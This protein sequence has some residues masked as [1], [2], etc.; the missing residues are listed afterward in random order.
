MSDAL[1]QEFP[2]IFVG[3]TTRRYGLSGADQLPHVEACSAP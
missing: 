2:D 3:R 1:R